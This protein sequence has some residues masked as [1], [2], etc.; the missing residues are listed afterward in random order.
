MV[1]FQKL[2]YLQ[3]I[4]NE[5]FRLYPKVTTNEG[6]AFTDSSYQWRVSW[7]RS[8]LCGGGPV[9]VSFCTFSRRKDLCIEDAEEQKPEE[10]NEDEAKPK[11]YIDL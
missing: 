3:M 10:W 2:P 1:V 9:T 5:T 4:I 11:I 8:N 7:H 6:V